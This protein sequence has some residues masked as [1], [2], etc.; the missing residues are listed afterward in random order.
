MGGAELID[1]LSPCPADGNSRRC[2]SGGCVSAGAGEGAEN[3]RRVAGLASMPSAR[4]AAAGD[5]VYWAD[6]GDGAAA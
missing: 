3:A 2:G 6:S 5:C 4:T 1:V